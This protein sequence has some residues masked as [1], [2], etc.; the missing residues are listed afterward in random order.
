MGSKSTGSREH[1]AK[2]TREQGAKKSN[3]ENQ[4]GGVPYPDDPLQNLFPI[5]PAPHNPLAEPQLRS[6]WTD[7]FFL[8]PFC[9]KWPKSTRNLGD[10]N[11]DLGHFLVNKVPIQKSGHG[12]SIIYADL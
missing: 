8:I 6:Y 7:G 4:A 12:G 10:Y 5:L 1:E 2:K 9:S 11:K 3:L